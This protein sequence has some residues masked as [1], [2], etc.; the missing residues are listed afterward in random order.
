MWILPKGSGFYRTPT[1]YYRTRILFYQTS[2]VCVVRANV[3]YILLNPKTFT[4]DQT[5]V[6]YRI[7]CGFYRTA[8]GFLPSPVHLLPYAKLLLPNRKD[9]PG[10]PSY[11]MP[12]THCF[13]NQQ[14]ILPHSTLLPTP[15]QISDALQ[16]NQTT[17][18]NP[19][20]KTPGLSQ[21][22]VPIS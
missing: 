19:T 22:S 14:Q 10:S 6:F 9:R 5:C 1:T 18:K 15:Q 8:P 21:T 7:Q 12:N 17:R 3:E 13:K 2:H 20:H 16:L 4:V 11:R